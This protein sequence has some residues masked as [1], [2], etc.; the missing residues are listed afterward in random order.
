MYTGFNLKNININSNS[1][2]TKK[3]HDK[4]ETQKKYIRSTLKKYITADGIIDGSKIQE[5]WFP[6]VNADIF[7]SHSHADEKLAISLACWLYDKL[8]LVAFIDS[9]VWGYAN[10]LLKLIDDEYCLNKNN[11]I[12]DYNK[13]NYSTSHVHMMLMTALNKMI[14]KT[15]CI[16]FLNTENS[17]L[18]KDIGNRTLSPWIYSEIEITRTIQKKRPNR[19]K[20][21]FFSKGVDIRAQKLNESLKIKYPLDINHF[22]TID[23]LI[24]KNWRECGVTETYALDKLYEITGL[25]ST[26]I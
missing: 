21:S 10:D 13:R 6:E 4:F 11:N 20:T 7:I 18:L 9:C 24:L 3:W 19:P 2:Y 5:E 17:V 16:F 15:E 25:I 23:N 8:G 22:N 12:Y 1:P 26:K 14:D